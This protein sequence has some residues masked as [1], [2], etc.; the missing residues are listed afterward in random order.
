LAILCDLFGIVNFNA[1]NF[2]H[3][4]HLFVL[5]RPVWGGAV[6]LLRFLFILRNA[7]WAW[8]IFPLKRLFESDRELSLQ[9][10]F[11]AFVVSM[12]DLLNFGNENDMR[13][14]WLGL[15]GSD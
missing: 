14:R 4:C 15:F 5:P 13:V 2:K 9:E 10:N 6:G 7:N 3:D 1:F 11:R 8:L 12:I